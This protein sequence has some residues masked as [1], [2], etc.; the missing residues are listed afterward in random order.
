MA[1]PRATPTREL[2]TG[3][4]DLGL[5]QRAL[6]GEREAVDGL[7]SR[8]AC[9]SRFAHRL[10]R[11]LGYGMT[12]DALEDVVQQVYAA[13]WSRLPD[14]TGSAALETWAYGFCRN[15]LRGEYRRRGAAGRAASLP[16][17][18][19][20][21]ISPGGELPPDRLLTRTE[22]LDALQEELSSLTPEEHEA[23]RLRHLEGWSFENIARQLGL[24]ASTVKDRC[25]RA[26]SRMR[27]RL[28]RRRVRE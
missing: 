15:C 26:L 1:S 17:E 27:A 3:P 28:I 25:Y 21:R 19:L 20:E 18:Q 5:V 23:V 2:G 8:L 13:L 7:L 12:A 10:N 6:R 24:P 4:G 16:A 9:I 22:R 14:Y 11:L